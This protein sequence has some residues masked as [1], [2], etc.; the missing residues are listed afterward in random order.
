MA[1][2]TTLSPD[3]VAERYRVLQESDWNATEA[4]KKLGLHGSS[5]TG[6]RHSYDAYA[7]KELGLDPPPIKS[8]KKVPKKVAKKAIVLHK[9]QT[10]MNAQ[11]LMAVLN[12]QQSANTPELYQLVGFA[13]Q[14]QHELNK[15]IVGLLDGRRRN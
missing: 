6:F 13:L 11:A 9:P 10:P 8:F 12:G 5:L 4:G 2:K 7:R 15:M 14:Q 3:V 1:G